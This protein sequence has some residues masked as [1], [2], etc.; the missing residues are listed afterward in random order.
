MVVLGVPVPAQRAVLRRVAR[1]F[2][3]RG[4]DEVLAFARELLAAGVHEARQVAFEFVAGRA[5]V[6]ATLRGADVEALGQ[7]NDN[8]ASVDCFGVYLAGPAWRIGAVSDARVLRWTRSADRWWRR[9]AL[10]A[11]VALNVK[12]RGGTGDVDRTLAV[13]EALVDDRDPM[14]AKAL[15]WSLRSLAGVDAAAVECFLA[16]HGDAVGAPVRREV[17]NKLRTGLKRG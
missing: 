2:R 15:S 17:G 12:S 13:C 14:V 9:T 5:D 7:G 3:S 11:T 16:A 8:W 10:V 6:M 1:A 4:P